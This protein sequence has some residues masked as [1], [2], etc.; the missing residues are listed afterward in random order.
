MDLAK[1]EEW[2]IFKAFG[3]RAERQSDREEPLERPKQSSV[4]VED[5]E[6]LRSKQRTETM[7]LQSQQRSFFDE[8][9][10]QQSAHEAQLAAELEALRGHCD[11]AVKQQGQGVESLRQQQRRMQQIQGQLLGDVGSLKSQLVD[12]LRR[13]ARSDDT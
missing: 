12:S 8:L 7:Q 4:G 6:L 9:L 13:S 10:G 1:K 5:L 2:S 11:E 3:C